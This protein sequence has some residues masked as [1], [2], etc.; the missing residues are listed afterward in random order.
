MA[1]KMQF[2][3][4]KV[5]R[6]WA[7]K[8]QPAILGPRELKFFFD[9]VWVQKRFRLSTIEICET[10]LLRLEF[11]MFLASGALLTNF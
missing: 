2:C 1:E 8:L 4:Q 5:L 6:A 10:L 11:T 3:G 7:Q 9:L